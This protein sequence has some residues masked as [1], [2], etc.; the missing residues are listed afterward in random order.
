M[1]PLEEI[2]KIKVE[3]EELESA[4]K[5]IADTRVREV[6]EIRIEECQVRLRQLQVILRK[7]QE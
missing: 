5:R 3:V 1:F 6:I 4:L 2:A 7:R